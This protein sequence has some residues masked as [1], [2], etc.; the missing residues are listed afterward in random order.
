MTPSLPSFDLQFDHAALRKLERD[1]WSNTSV[2][3][4]LKIED[5]V[6]DIHIR[7]RGS[8]TR[9]LK[10]KSYH[11]EFSSQRALD[12]SPELHLNAES[13]DPSHFRNKLS[14]DF[15]R[16]LG[17]H[18]PES[19]HVFVTLDGKPLGLYLQLE[20]VDEIYLKKRNL[21]SGTIYY[22][23]SDKAD[24]SQKG[25]RGLTSGYQRKLGNMEDDHTLIHFI[26]R[27]NSPSNFSHEIPRL[28]HIENYLR[29]L[30]GAVCTM[31]NDG[32]THNY[33]LYL[34]R[35]EQLFSIIPWDYDATFG[36][37]VNGDVM[38]WDYVPITGKTK[39]KLT[40]QLMK[41]SGFRKLYK[42][43]LEEILDT[44]FTV[45]YLE[46]NVM[47]LHSSLRPYILM[48][49]HFQK[50]IDLY[51]REP[52]FILQF[53]EDRGAYLRQELKHL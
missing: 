10:K 30:A 21:P 22:A 35:R 43:I 47:S 11:I 38:E 44:T 13:M 37:R 3:A 31:N 1:V 53:I 20:S 17:I 14:L 34:N 51:D 26:K 40:T 15:M 33:A 7:Y 6:H 8:Y 5:A 45:E 12:E 29:W 24:F 36:R 4:Q 32:F 49:P 39:N 52:S 2:P 28:L 19:K 16:E 9:E 46:D 27:I 18:T 50:D 42:D 25:K 23:V 41:R 48:D